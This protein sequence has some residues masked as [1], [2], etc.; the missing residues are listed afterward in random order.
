MRLAVLIFMIAGML[1]QR[2]SSWW[3]SRWYWVVL[4]ALVVATATVAWRAR[5]RSHFLRQSVLESA[6]AG[7]IAD[8]DRQM[9]REWERSH[10]LEM[11]VSN[12]P[13]GS[14]LDAV[15][16]SIRSQCPDALC[17]VI[18]LKTS[19][20]CQVEASLDMP[21]E[22]LKAL[23]VLHTV[24]YEVWGGPL[25]DR[26]PS[27]DPAWKLFTSRIGGPPPGIVYS[28][29]I[30]KAQEQPGAIL[31]FYREGAIPG[32]SAARAIEIA[33]RTARL[34]IE[35]SRLYD[36]LHYQAH[37]DNL[38]GLPNRALFEERL[39]RS[40][41]EADL[42]GQRV[43]VLFV[44]LDRFKRVN[45][46]FSHRI[47]DLFLREMAGRMKTALRPVDTIAR[48]GG[49]EFTIV[50]NDVKDAGEA[51]EIADRVMEAIRQ[52]LVIEGHEIGASASIGIAVFPDD[53]RDIE[54]L[55]RAADAAMYCAKDLGRDR[56]QAFSTRNETLDRVRMDEEL[57][58][59]LREGYFI[60]HYQPKVGVDR[61]LAG[62]EALV[63]MNHPVH[64]LIP[65]L[66][67]IPVAESNGLIVPLG[68]WVL[69]EACRQVAAWE[70]RGLSPISVAVNVSPVQICR[71]DFAKSV[72]DCLKR[73]R[74][75]PSS[76][77]LELTESLL[78]NAV[79][80]AQEQLQA[81]RALGVRLSIDDFGT[82]YSSLS[83]LHRL[84]VDAIKLDR[85]FVQSIDTDHLAHRLVHAMIG[86]AHGL[87]LNVVAEGVET[88]GQRDA[89]L[90]AGCSLMQ[91]FLFA[92]PQ[93]ACDLEGFLCEGDPAASPRVDLKQLTASMQLI[94][95]LAAEPVPV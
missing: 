8:L 35:Q 62:F 86:V 54:K 6:V 94:D 59:A 66:S 53:G 82:G 29:P 69:D 5:E 9:R 10:I 88:E 64:G 91:G 95:K 92:R 7:R 28:R 27:T 18:L 11:L 36:S 24:P 63:R 78:I 38:T 30:S 71:P 75:A 85:S 31:L 81:L 80:V 39:E 41:G 58:V 72:E 45:D 21:G 2:S 77:E 74:V 76:L 67:F 61:K 84:P 4:A 65:P 52:P 15:L 46:T 89:L 43:A 40:L 12:E 42:L 37:H 79:G 50:L 23:R 49:D 16:R 13:L 73:H 83:Y 44:D 87:G 26:R 3:T 56:T 55:Q 17:A 90:T 68:A 51:S 34:A 1:E 70:S 60:V 33:V 20:G 93:P 14:V 32:E 57:R 48:I 22:W 19:D 47:G 25:S